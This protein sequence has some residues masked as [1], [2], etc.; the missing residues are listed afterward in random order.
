VT[1]CRLYPAG[2]EEHAPGADS[3]EIVL[4]LIRLH[5]GVLRDDGLKEVA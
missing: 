1:F 3:R 4:D 5:G 2:V